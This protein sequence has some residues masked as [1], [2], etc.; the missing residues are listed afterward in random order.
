MCLLALLVVGR[1]STQPRA[2][3]PGFESRPRRAPPLVSCTSRC[4]VGCVWG[5]WW[6]P[7]FELHVISSMLSEPEALSSG[8]VCLFICAARKL[9]NMQEVFQVG[10][11]RGDIL[12]MQPPPVKPPCGVAA[13]VL[14]HTNISCPSAVAY[15][16]ALNDRRSRASESRRCSAC[17]ISRIGIRTSDM[18]TEC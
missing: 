17:A 14:V 3:P 13:D 12:R 7:R 9:W 15:L 6:F 5:F 2:C 10:I 16:T 11:V 1:S 18:G 8:I 4:S